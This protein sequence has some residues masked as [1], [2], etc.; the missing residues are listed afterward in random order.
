MGMIFD[1]SKIRAAGGEEAFKMLKGEELN[2]VLAVASQMSFRYIAILPA[3][4]LLVFGA[5]WV[6]DKSKGGYKPV[7]LAVK[8]VHGESQLP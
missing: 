1:H 4:L 7:K 2:R 8:P 6:Y 3:I 5:I